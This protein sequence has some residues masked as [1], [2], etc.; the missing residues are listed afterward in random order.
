MMNTKYE[1]KED[2]E[3]TEII[4]EMS[5]SEERDRKS[6]RLNSSH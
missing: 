5:E 3:E 4:D 1:L 2:E 6:T